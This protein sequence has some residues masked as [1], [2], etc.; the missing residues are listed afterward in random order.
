MAEFGC[1]RKPYKIVAYLRAC[2]QR[3]VNPLDERRF[4]K[5]KYNCDLLVHVISNCL[6][7]VKTICYHE[8][9]S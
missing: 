4:T 5:A 6:K 1:W 7:T 3:A 2:L 9:L 8:G